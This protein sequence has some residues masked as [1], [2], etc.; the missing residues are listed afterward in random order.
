LPEEPFG[1]AW[2]DVCAWRGRCLN[3]FANAEGEITQ[4]LRRTIEDSKLPRLCGQRT[5]ALLDTLTGHTSPAL[6]AC[7]DALKVWQSHEPQRAWVAHG[8]FS[9]LLDRHGCWSAIVRFVAVGKT[10]AVEQSL[11]FTQTEAAQF[12]QALRS[13]CN[14]LRTKLQKL[15]VNAAL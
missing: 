7:L 13:A 5:K 8:T 11:V 12:E 10:G 4:A 6:G 14:K 15:P 2:I 9:A 3:V 1:Q